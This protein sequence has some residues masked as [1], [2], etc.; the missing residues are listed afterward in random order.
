MEASEEN[1]S[2]SQ[3]AQKLNAPDKSP[4]LRAVEAMADSG[5]RLEDI[6][7]EEDIIRPKFKCSSCQKKESDLLSREELISKETIDLEE[8]I[9][10]MNKHKSILEELIDQEDQQRLQIALNVARDLKLLGKEAVE[11][12]KKDLAHYFKIGNEKWKRACEEM[13]KLGPLVKDIESHSSFKK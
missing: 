5:G 11:T 8:I 7:E 2:D 1:L 6:K 13:E 10:Y 4:K 9:S 12:L 3:L